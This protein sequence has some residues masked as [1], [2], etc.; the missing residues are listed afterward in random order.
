MGW[1]P[2]EKVKSYEIIKELNQGGNAIAYSAKD[3]KGEKVFF[4]QYIS[5]TVRVSWY[6]AYIMYQQELKNRVESTRFKDFSYRFIDFFEHERR[7]YQ[8]F[9]FVD[10]GLSL[11]DFLDKVKVGKAA[12]PFEQRMIMA[13]V[14]M[15][16]IHAMHEAKIVHSDLKPG[17][18]M[19]IP[20]TDP[21]I[22]AKYK[23]KVIDMDFSLL[24]DRKAP[25][26]G[27]QGYMGTPGYM[28]PEHLRG[29]VPQPA[30]DI[31]TCGLI[32]YELLSKEGHPYP[33]ETWETDILKFK[34]KP[35]TLLGKPEAPASEADL[36][37]ILYRCLSPK[38]EERPTAQDLLFVLN[39]RKIAMTSTPRPKPPEEKAEE[40]KEPATPEK[41]DAAREDTTPEASTPPAKAPSPTAPPEA[42]REAP[43][44][45]TPARRLV[46]A[47]AD[48]KDINFGVAS[49]VG[50][51]LVSQLGADSQFWTDP[52]FALEKETDGTWY[53][54]PRAEATNA[55]LLNGKTLK[56][57]TA[58]KEGD[59]VAVGNE[60]KGVSKLPLTVT[61]R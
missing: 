19:L 20:S 6:R 47:N 1:K 10:K 41:P 33:G 29:E 39:G 27:E 21:K 56:E 38:P 55:T 36:Q 32:L 31:F 28:S 61:F 45:P 5:P 35:P 37:D 57:R 15:G 8:V 3:A 11:D 24:A 16:G 30:S 26:H 58:L 51:P 42:S 52:Q 7:Y 2:G 46:L 34:A 59:V 13:K 18:L 22:R 14:M 54:L 53:V 50:R 44:K 12:A 49:L 40:K 60:S 25:W 43:P 23:L 4:K 9:E 48:G 17:N